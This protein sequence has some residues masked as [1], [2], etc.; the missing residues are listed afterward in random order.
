MLKKTD[1]CDFEI[2]TTF[3]GWIEEPVIEILDSTSYPIEEVAFPTVTLCP[4]SGNS[5]RWGAPIKVFDNMKV[6]CPET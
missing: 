2:Q 6:V 1:I 5:D 4:K 3:A